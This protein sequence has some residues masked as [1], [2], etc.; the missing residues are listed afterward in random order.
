MDSARVLGAAKVIAIDKEPYRLEMAAAEGYT[1]VNFENEDVR[2]TL[3]ERRPEAMNRLS[4]LD[5]L[6]D[7]PGK[8][9]VEVGDDA[10]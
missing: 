4:V 3:L 8:L 9:D 5:D 2:S 6:A 10:A 7:P 1:T